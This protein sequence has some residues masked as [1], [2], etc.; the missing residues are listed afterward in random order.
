MNANII[1]DIK[2]IKIYILSEDELSKLAGIGLDISINDVTVLEDGTL[3]YK[4][5]RT[6]LYIRDWIYPNFMF[7]IAKLYK[8]WGQKEE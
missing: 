6:V 1:Q 7:Q 2:T 4:N 5:A 3:S 8:T